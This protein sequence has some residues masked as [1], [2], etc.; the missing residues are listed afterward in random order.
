[1]GE[2]Y[3]SGYVWCQYIYIHIHIT[4]YIFTELFNHILTRKHFTECHWIK[5]AENKFE[6]TIFK[7]VAK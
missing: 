2:L 1:M 7:T 6:Y 3:S 5:I 4:I